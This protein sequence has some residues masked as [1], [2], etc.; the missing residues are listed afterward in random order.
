M[1]SGIDRSFRYFFSLVLL[2]CV[3]ASCGSGAGGGGTHPGAIGSEGGTVGPSDLSG[4]VSSAKVYIPQGALAAEEA[5]SLKAVSLP[6]ALPVG[7][8]AA[9]PCVSFSPEGIT[10][11]QKASLYLPYADANNDGYVD[12]KGV[13]ESKVGVLYYNQGTGAWEIMPVQGRDGKGNLVVAQTAHFSTYLAVVDTGDSTPLDPGTSTGTSTLES[14]DCLV[15]N[16]NLQDSYGDTDACYYYNMTVT[17]RTSGLFAV[18]DRFATYVEAGFPATV[19]SDGMSATF[20]AASTFAKVRE[21]GDARLWNWEA[22]FVKEHT[23]LMDYEV[24]DDVLTGTSG[25]GI[26]AS[27]EAVD[28][29]MVKISW[30][31]DLNEQ[32]AYASTPSAGG[33]LLVVRFRASF[34]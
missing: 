10:F 12:G 18:V 32:I 14:G 8:E 28:A 4:L 9:G 30:G 6:K 29:N 19:S 25:T 20:D 13:P 3:L 26:Y 31:I 16:A 15:G 5:I 23:Y 7:Y 21:S 34:Q 1:T 24:L 11:A 33:H 2:G 27:I 17:R 22:E